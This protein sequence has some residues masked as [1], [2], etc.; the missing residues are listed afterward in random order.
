ME[1]YRDGSF[2][3]LLIKEFEMKFYIRKKL[4]SIKIKFHATKIRLSLTIYMNT[5]PEAML[6]TVISVCEQYKFEIILRKEASRCNL[7][8]TGGKS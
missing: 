7:R 3:F 2:P 6:L 8:K 4:N 1:S 5:L